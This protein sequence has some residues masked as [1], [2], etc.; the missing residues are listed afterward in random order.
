MSVGRP[1]KVH[2]VE[3]ANIAREYFAGVRLSE[4]AR[5]HGIS[6]SLALIIAKQW[7]RKRLERR[8]Q[9]RA[10]RVPPS[11]TFTWKPAPPTPEIRGDGTYVVHKEGIAITLPLCSI[12]Q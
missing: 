3:R 11:V 5:D 1:L 8:S 4:V 7:E 6:P 10:T 12:Q 2:P 9:M